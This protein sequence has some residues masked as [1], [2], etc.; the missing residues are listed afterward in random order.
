VTWW[1]GSDRVRVE[2]RFAELYR[3]EF[4]SVFRTVLAL[5]GDREVAE[6][7]A[8]EAFA[9]ALARWRRLR[10]RPWTAGWITT[11]AMNVA[12]RNLRRRPAIEPG[13]PATPDLDASM[14]LWRE[15]RML[16]ERQ[17]EAVVLHYVLD[18]PVSDVAQAMRCEEGTVKTHLSRARSAL[19][20]A[21]EEARDDA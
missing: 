6:E 19:R 3:A 8:Q 2:P 10:D 16:P 18:L 1:E 14:D 13:E 20:V 17:Q 15:V 5:C 21:L 11:T 4:Q 7:A 9:R 12:R